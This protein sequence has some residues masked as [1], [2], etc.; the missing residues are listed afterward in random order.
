MQKTLVMIKA[1]V[2]GSNARQPQ[3]H[4]AGFREASAGGV[5][6]KVNSPISTCNSDISELRNSIGLKIILIWIGFY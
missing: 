1:Y 5:A 4:T 3:R 6:R 2:I